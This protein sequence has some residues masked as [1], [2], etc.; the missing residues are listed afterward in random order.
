MMNPNMTWEE[1]I[2]YC[3][4]HKCE[5]CIVFST[6]DCRTQHEKENMHVPCCVNLVS[7]SERR[8]LCENLGR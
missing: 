4:S 6:E 2:K 7:E 8:I 1:A 3:E 5:E